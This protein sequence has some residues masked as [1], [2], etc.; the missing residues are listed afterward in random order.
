MTTYGNFNAAAVNSG[1]GLFICNLP[2]VNS[3]FYRIYKEAKSR[4][5]LLAK[6]DK[7]VNFGDES[8]HQR[9]EF[10]MRK[11]YKSL[12]GLHHPIRQ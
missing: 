2:L 9:K 12:P 8:L 4:T 7:A 6:G 1:F 10:Y 5:K 3:L 11:A